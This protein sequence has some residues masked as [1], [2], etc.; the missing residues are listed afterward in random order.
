M[1]KMACCAIILLF[2]LNLSAL[3]QKDFDKVVDFSVTL[4]ELHELVQ[5]KNFTPAAFTKYFIISG[6]VASINPINPAE[7]NFLAEL[8]T[9]NGEWKNL[10]SVAMYKAFVYVQGR[11]FYRRIPSRTVKAQPGLSIEQNRQVIVAGVLAD[12]YVDEKGRRFPVVLAS[13][14]RIL[15]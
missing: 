14:L 13:H 1:K 8:E 6:S 5:N 7:E 9:V 11:D 4:K 3:D 12:V 15:N 2:G 10:D